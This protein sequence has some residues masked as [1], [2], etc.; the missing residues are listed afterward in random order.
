MSGVAAGKLRHW[1]QLQ[2]QQ[3]AQDPNTGEMVNTWVRL[4]DVWA[5]VAPASGR[6]FIAAAA[7]Q[8]EVRGRITIRYRDDVDAT[9]RVVHRGKTYAILAALEDAESGLE[10]LTLMVAEGVRIT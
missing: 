3:S 5:D 2:R 6:E 4:A 9:M 1:V 7:E 8:S 10:H